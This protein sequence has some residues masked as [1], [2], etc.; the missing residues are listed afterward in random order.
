METV[1]EFYR[2]AIINK[3]PTERIKQDVIALK[4]RF[5]KILYCFNPQKALRELEKLS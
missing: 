1:A 5:N 2:R 3:E 4:Q